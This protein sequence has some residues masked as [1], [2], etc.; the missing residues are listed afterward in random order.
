VALPLLLGL[1][2]FG[3]QSA[4]DWLML[5]LLFGVGVGSNLGAK[6]SSVNKSPELQ[7]A[8]M[9]TLFHRKD[10]SSQFPPLFIF[11]SFLQ[12]HLTLS[13][14]YFSCTEE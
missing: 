14:H 4:C 3:A 5:H 11:C 10:F 8:K 1:V 12:T 6:R 9:A 13:T 7:T 2:E